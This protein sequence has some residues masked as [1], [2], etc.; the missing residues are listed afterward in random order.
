M[1]QLT[2]PDSSHRERRGS[3]Q[4]LQGGWAISDGGEI[5]F[6]HS[7]QNQLPLIQQAGAGWI[8][9]GFRLGRCYS[10]WASRGCN[11]LTAL[12]QYDQV[13]NDAQSR[14]LKILGLINSESWT[15]GQTAW[16]ANNAE[17]TRGN[18]DNA[19]LQAVS[20]H[21]AVV[22]ATHYAGII[23]TWEVWNEPNA[24][25]ANPSP[26]VYT[27]G[28]YIYPSN[29]AWL[30]RHLYEDTRKA[31]LTGLTFVSGGVFGHDL[32]GAF[33]SGSDYITAT[34]NQGLAHAGWRSVKQAHGSYP[35]DAI[36]QHLYVD[37]GRVT[38]SRK[39]TK[40]LNAVRN[41]YVAFE[42]STTTKTTVVTEV[43]WTTASVSQRNQADNL[44]LAYSVFK[45]TTYVKNA[46]WFNIQDVPEAKLSFGLQ[47]SGS[48]SDTYM[49]VH[50]SSFSIYQQNANY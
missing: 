46:Y 45:K 38:S 25:T 40:Y 21:V 42:G 3:N 34:Y 39:I 15:G 48:D 28:N 17:H 2:Q 16:T 5:D 36:G 14:G 11:G 33:S 41:A 8:R 19:Y 26:G 12:Q 10:D 50:K 30:L 24:W 44:K 7:L 20:R 29:F 27:G 9:I 43:G 32:R 49:G 23:T 47:T 6:P 31:G 18:G 13:I 4:G 37:Q 35:L 1:D 22:L